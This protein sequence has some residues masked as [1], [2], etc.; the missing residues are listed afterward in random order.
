M[1]RK[2]GAS[3]L[4][5]HD[6]CKS[7]SGART[8]TCRLP[9]DAFTGTPCCYHACRR[10]PAPPTRPTQAPNR[11][12]YDYPAIFSG[13]VT[14][15]K[16]LSPVAIQTCA[17]WRRWVTVSFCIPAHEAHERKQQSSPK[18]RHDNTVQRFPGASTF[19]ITS[20]VALKPA[21]TAASGGRRLQPS[22]SD[23]Q[24][25]AVG[26]TGSPPYQHKTR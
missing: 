15:N 12:Q 5:V 10:S 8:G 26:S 25:A 20:W 23:L 4:F 18:F 22:R 21:C 1:T 7:L 17:A 11:R 24:L 14:V 16:W 13:Y 2:D 6:D 19:E 9:R 3:T